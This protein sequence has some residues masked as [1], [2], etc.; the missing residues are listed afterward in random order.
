MTIPS[1]RHFF[2]FSDNSCAPP[3]LPRFD[4]QYRPEKMLMKSVADFRGLKRMQVSLSIASMALRMMRTCSE[5]L[6][7]TILVNLAETSASNHLQ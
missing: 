7:I 4:L 3:V 6:N 2:Q 1:R 5:A